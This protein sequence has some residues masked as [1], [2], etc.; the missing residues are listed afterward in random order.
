MNVNFLISIISY[1]CII[2][3]GVCGVF[4]VTGM[5]GIFSLGQG[6]FM[7]LGA[8]TSAILT[9]NFHFPFIVRFCSN[10]YSDIK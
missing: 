8:Y 5:T 1:T 7:A 2:L 10:S 6:A 9:K 3:I 4:L